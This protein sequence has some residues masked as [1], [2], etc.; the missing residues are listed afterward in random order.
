MTRFW[1]VLACVAVVLL[2][3][4]GMWLGWRSRAKRQSFL[5]ALPGLPDDLGAP[6][7]TSTGLYVGTTFAG[8][9][10]DRV[11][12]DG[13]GARAYGSATLYPA[14]LLIERDGAEPVFVPRADLLGVRL[15]PGLAGKVMGDGGLLVARWRLGESELDTGFRADD[16]ST[17]PD[18]IRSLSAMSDGSP[19][20]VTPDSPSLATKTRHSTEGVQ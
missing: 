1:L 16:K 7:M 2:A 9:W 17:Y 15:A 4:V 10:Q 20:R 19:E 11:V 12:H 6:T 5:P 8:S 3:L 13:L 18:W 14:G